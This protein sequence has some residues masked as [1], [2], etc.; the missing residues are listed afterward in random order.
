M[1]WSSRFLC[2]M[3]ECLASDSESEKGTLRRSDISCSKKRDLMYA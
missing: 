1:I 2:S 3:V